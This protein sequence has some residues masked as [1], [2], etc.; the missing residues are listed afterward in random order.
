MRRK[1]L[2]QDADQLS[3]FDDFWA[4]KGLQEAEVIEEEL[5]VV[6]AVDENVTKT[7]VK[8]VSNTSLS[9]EEQ[10]L[11]ITLILAKY[12]VD[13]SQY[14]ST[15]WSVVHWCKLDFDLFM[16]SQSVP[17]DLTE[18]ILTAEQHTVDWLKDI[19]SADSLV[20]K[21]KKFIRFTRLGGLYDASFAV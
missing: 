17:E 6:S 5:P 20:C 18:D 3:F 12:G 1:Q 21:F 9:H 11:F 16:P 7:I 10:V 19:F 4:N 8:K 2:L 14:T 15:R 13:V